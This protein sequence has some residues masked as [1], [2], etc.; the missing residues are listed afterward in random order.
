MQGSKKLRAFLL[1]A[2]VLLAL[3]VAACGGSGGGAPTGNTGTSTK[4][5]PAPADKQV[6]R[7]PE[8]AIDDF[9]TLDPALVQSASDAYVIQTIFTGLVQ[10]KDDGT[11]VDQL[12]AS[13]TVS[14]DGLTYTFTLRPNLKFSDGSP[15]TAQD[16][17]WSIDRALKPAT[18]SQVINYLNLLKDW[19]KMTSGK[20]PTLIGDSI[21]VKDPSTIQ[22][23]ISKPA[24]YFLQALTYPISYPV[25][26]KLIDQYGEKWTDHLTEGGG[27]GP[28]KVAS[29]SHTKGI[30]VV[31][32]PNYYGPQPKLQKIQF[33]FSGDSDTTFKAYLSGQYDYTGVPS[34]LYEQYKDHKDFHRTPAL[35][36]GYLT[37]NYLAK[38]FDDIKVRQ[39]FAL[40][41]NK[42]LLVKSVL[43]NAHS[44]TNHIVPEGMF[45]YNKNLTG[46]LG[47]TATK[48]D[49]E[50]A[51]QLLQESSYAGK[52][53]PI[54]L[55]YY[56]GSTTTKNVITAVA[57]QW[58]TVLGIDVKTTAV[59]FNKLIE[60][61]NGTKG[62]ANLQM[63]YLNW[64]A[65]YVDPQDW[66]GV[67]F[68]KNA[69][70][71][72][73]NYGQN[74]TAVA[75]QQ[76]AVQEQLQKADVTQDQN[77]R[78]KLY[79]DAEQKIV[80]DVG[81]I[82][83]FQFNTNTLINPKLYGYKDTPL[84]ITAPDDWADIYFTQ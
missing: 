71:N 81:W 37:M 55:T 48:G 14:S 59:D 34:A 83:L 56:T 39:A 76:Q 43:K 12:A 40:A 45:G 73:I 10:F 2:L 53:P 11:V 60:I 19:D 63:W 66:L 16:V 8:F 57:Q 22:L 72:L 13:H 6:F 23:I 33:T 61:T 64:Q 51:K 65:D 49:Q 25:Q 5:A 47:V 84:G 79:N 27:C 77:E 17:A 7:Y 41:L 52:L 28:F 15:L 32:N 31:P 46:P 44:P 75:A 1:P 9:G 30:E 50:K 74:N 82:P 70:N 54:T 69:D 35:V 20:I 3:L 26:K 68:E 58:K 18:K 78:L 4:P 80:N 21:I 29:Y 38:P 24:A 67:F 36:I 42:D 62:N